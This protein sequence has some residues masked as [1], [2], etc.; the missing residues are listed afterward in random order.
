MT[1]FIE[2]NTRGSSRN[3]TFNAFHGL[4]VDNNSEGCKKSRV[5][6]FVKIKI[7]DNIQYGLRN[8]T[9]RL[10]GRCQ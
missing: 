9:L 6:W 1:F 10:K 5:K 2:S 4:D 8:L 7:I 3:P